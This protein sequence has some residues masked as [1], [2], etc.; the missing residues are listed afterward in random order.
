MSLIST[1]AAII[2]HA[3]QQKLLRV[4]LPGLP[5]TARPTV[6]RRSYR[7]YSRTHAPYDCF[8]APTNQSVFPI[9]PPALLPAVPVLRMPCFARVIQK[10]IA[11][12]K[13]SSCH[14]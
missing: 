11:S 14:S 3:L 12:R 13:E 6:S 10:D 7:L 4:T 1:V 8:S 5:F 9:L 2:C